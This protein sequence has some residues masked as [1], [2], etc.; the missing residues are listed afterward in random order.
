M[1]AQS[2]HE[3]VVEELVARRFHVAQRRNGLHII[4][5]D[6]P[7]RELI[8]H[9][10][11]APRVGIRDDGACRYVN[12]A[13]NPGI[14]FY[15]AILRN[16]LQ[17]R[18]SG[19]D[20]VNTMLHQLFAYILVVID[21]IGALERSLGIVVLYDVMV[22]HSTTCFPKSRALSASASI[23]VSVAGRIRPEVWL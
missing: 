9:L 5:T 15:G 17:M 21:E 19:K 18:M 20:Q 6:L 8:V 4:G 16:V 11:S 7:L 14:V 13:V 2:V 3:I 22:L 10:D 1:P 23:H 12:Q